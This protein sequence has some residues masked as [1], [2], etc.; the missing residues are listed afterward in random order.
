MFGEGKRGRNGAI[1]VGRRIGEGPATLRYD[2]TNTLAQMIIGR[3]HKMTSYLPRCGTLSTK[4]ENK[5]ND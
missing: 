4:P 1:D 5:P 2:I 3:L